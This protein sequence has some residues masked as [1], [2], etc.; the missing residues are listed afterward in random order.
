MTA[1]NV[2]RQRRIRKSAAAASSVRSDKVERARRLV[3][4]P[5][6]PGPEI[7]RAI[8]ERLVEKLARSLPKKSPKRA[9]SRLKLIPY[10]KSL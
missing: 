8:A 1:K 10:A 9:A 4:N 3:A 7:T 2:I 5:R 6:Y